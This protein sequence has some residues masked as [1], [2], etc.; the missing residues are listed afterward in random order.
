MKTKNVYYR[1]ISR[2]TLCNTRHAV[3]L[4]CD[5]DR[6][7]RKNTEGRDISSQRSQDAE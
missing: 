5:T 7:L 2:A 4:N 1:V 3:G 6:K